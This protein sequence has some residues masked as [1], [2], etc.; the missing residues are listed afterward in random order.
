MEG[1][2]YGRELPDFSGGETI[3]VGRG[4]RVCDLLWI[5]RRGQGGEDGGNGQ[6]LGLRV[7]SDGNGNPFLNFVFSRGMHFSYIKVFRPRSQLVN[8]WVWVYIK[9]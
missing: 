2:F 9:P 8:F 3:K 6:R 4:L 1:T 7:L 5:V